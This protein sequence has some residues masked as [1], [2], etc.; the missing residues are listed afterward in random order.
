MYNGN[1]AQI[2]FIQYDPP[3]IARH[4]PHI[5]WA[6]RIKDVYIDVRISDG[7]EYSISINERRSNMNRIDERIKI[8]GNS[9]SRRKAQSEITQI[10]SN[11]WGIKARFNHSKNVTGYPF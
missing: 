6:G 8:N 5:F 7:F 10:F 11:K 2:Q 4:S 9:E 3:N 1:N